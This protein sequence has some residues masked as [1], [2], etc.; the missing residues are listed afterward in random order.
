MDIVGLSPMAALRHRAQSLGYPLEYR[1]VR[2]EGPPHAPMYSHQAICGFLVSGGSG[3]SKRSSLRSCAQYMLDMLTGRISLTNSQQ[4][5]PPVPD[6]VHTQREY[7]NPCGSLLRLCMIMGLPAPLYT[8]EVQEQGAWNY[9]CTCSVP[10]LVDE[11]VGLTKKDARRDAGQAV[12]IQ[13]K[14]RYEES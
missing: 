2:A 3:G 1:L 4:L 11:G 6:T 14:F 10:G 5:L 8:Y 13:L 7:A 9:V 12:Y